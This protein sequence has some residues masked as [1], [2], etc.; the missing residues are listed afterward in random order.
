MRLHSRRL[1]AY[2]YLLPA[3]AFILVV[4]IYPVYRILQTSFLQTNADGSKSLGLANYRLVFNDPVFWSAAA[5]NGRLLLSVPIMTVLGLILAL[6]LFE[7]TRGWQAYR[8][9]V[10]LP[11]ILAVTVVGTTF[12]YLLG[13][14]GIFNTALRGIGLAFLAQDW[15]GSARWVVP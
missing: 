11:Y 15:L 3:T 10:F 8:T 9:L 2:L 13:L 14:N 7:R 5:N 6:L 4:F 12:V 1:A